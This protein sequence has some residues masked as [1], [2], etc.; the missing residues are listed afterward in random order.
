MVNITDDVR[1]EF[2]QFEDS[3]F[4]SDS[5]KSKTRNSKKKTKK[6]ENAFD[7][8]LNDDQPAFSQSYNFDSLID[9]L[10]DK[11]NDS[12]EE[13]VI[14]DFGFAEKSLK[15]NDVTIKSDKSSPIKNSSFD[16]ENLIKVDNDTEIK[17]KAEE[18]DVDI[19]DTVIGPL[20]DKAKEIPE[21][22]GGTSIENNEKTKDSPTK[23]NL[24]T[25]LNDSTEKSL[26]T[27]N[28]P[29]KTEDTE[30]NLSIS[31][32]GNQSTEPIDKTIDSDTTNLDGNGLSEKTD[33]F[34]N[35]KKE[36]DNVSENINV[37]NSTLTPNENIDNVS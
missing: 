30:D 6:T 26:E 23:N 37:T 18:M 10:D 29:L 19:T 20:T 2:E 32:S 3:D 27:N 22:N 16:I 34:D 35:V 25:K 8:L 33:V 5:E 17:L 15:N 1:K 11:N 13:S 4:L 9:S 14:K 21:N 31:Q 12:G 7:D 28:L 24:N 36:N